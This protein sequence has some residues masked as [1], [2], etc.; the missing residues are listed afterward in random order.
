MK[1]QNLSVK[2]QESLSDHVNHDIRIVE[3]PGFCGSRTVK[4]DDFDD[5]GSDFSIECLTCNK[6]IL[7]NH[8]IVA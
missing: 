1:Y 6:I 3:H 8:V 7:G 5:G 4:R 2:Q